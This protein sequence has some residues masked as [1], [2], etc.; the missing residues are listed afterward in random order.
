MNIFKIAFSKGEYSVSIP[1]YPGGDVVDYETAK[2]LENEVKRLRGI[3]ANA[4]LLIAALA[5]ESETK[6]NEP[7]R[8]N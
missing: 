6:P 1:D 7:K 5:G 8:L 3:I 4:Q 2:A